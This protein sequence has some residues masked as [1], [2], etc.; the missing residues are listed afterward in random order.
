M[1]GPPWGRET[2]G[3]R[4]CVPAPPENQVYLV[5]RPCVSGLQRAAT[6]VPPAQRMA[7][8]GDLI[9]IAAVP[10]TSLGRPTRSPAHPVRT[11][12]NCSTASPRQ[13]SCCRGSPCR[14]CICG[15]QFLCDCICGNQFLCAGTGRARDRTGIR[16]GLR[17]QMNVRHSAMNFKC[18]FSDL[19]SQISDLR[20]QISDLRSQISDLR[21]Q[22]SVPGR[23]TSLSARCTNRCTTALR[24]VD[25]RVR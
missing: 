22:I 18:E 21:S 8:C 1:G 11:A 19:S 6:A 24:G 3:C 9:S 14:H 4:L 25:F 2:S 5:V 23:P 7:R 15:N 20:S 12:S 13:Y 16:R 10:K 17:A